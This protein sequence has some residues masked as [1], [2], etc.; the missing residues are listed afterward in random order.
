MCISIY[1]MY[2]YVHI[3]MYNILHVYNIHV[4]I[5]THTTYTWYHCDMKSCYLQLN[6]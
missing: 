5:Y 1:N 2:L 4:Y 6:I 3:H